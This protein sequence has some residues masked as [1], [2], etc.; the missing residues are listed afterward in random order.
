MKKFNYLNLEHLFKWESDH[1]TF[2]YSV[3]KI[4]KLVQ[5]VALALSFQDMNVKGCS[6]VARTSNTPVKIVNKN[7]EEN[8]SKYKK[9]I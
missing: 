2:F 3:M 6:H 4:R 1:W 5:Q 9:G 7:V 8:L